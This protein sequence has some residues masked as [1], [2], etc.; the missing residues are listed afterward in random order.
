[1]PRPSIF[2]LPGY[3]YD[4]WIDISGCLYEISVLRSKQQVQAAQVKSAVAINSS[5]IQLYWNM[6]K[7]IMDNLALFEDRNN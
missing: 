5:L 6:G 2:V 4:Y 1:M 7:M 3:G